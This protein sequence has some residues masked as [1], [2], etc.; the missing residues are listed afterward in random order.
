MRF[1]SSVLVILVLPLLAGCRCAEEKVQEEGVTKEDSVHAKLD[2]NG[3]VKIDYEKEGD[4]DTVSLRPGDRVA[5]T[6]DGCPPGTQF[7]VQDLHLLVDL[8]QVVETLGEGPPPGQA[9]PQAEFQE[10]SREL[11][12][13]PVPGEGDARK[14]LIEGKIALRWLGDG[15]LVVTRDLQE[16]AAVE[17]VEWAPPDVFVDAGE[18]ILSGPVPKDVVHGVWKFTWKVRLRGKPGED[19][20]D[21]HLYTDNPNP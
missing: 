4:H 20:W 1:S 12:S 19:K 3:N 10:L 8:E 6:C 17:P 5:W 21:P 9:D 18:R 11:E 7:A 13:A 15:L 14:T 2:E 16:Q